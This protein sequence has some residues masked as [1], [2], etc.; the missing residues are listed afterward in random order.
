M[1]EETNNQ[2][3]EAAAEDNQPTFQLMRCYMKD[4]S[5][6]MPNAPQIFIEEHQ[7]QP[8]IGFQ[9]QVS[10]QPL[11]VQDAYEVVLRS[12]VTVGYKEKD[13]VIFL[14]ECKQAGIFEIKN[15]PAESLGQVLHVVC[16]SLILPYARANV[17]DM[18]NRTGFPTVLLPEVNFEAMFQHE[19]QQ[20][21]AEA[22]KAAK[23]TKTAKA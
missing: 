9:F 10:A 16:P 13:Q 18:I 11:P 12:T 2:Q 22:E 23:A 17:S 20:R 21:Q 1:A 8:T 4:A 5:L 3:P 6:E 14:V 7:E 15:L 19:M